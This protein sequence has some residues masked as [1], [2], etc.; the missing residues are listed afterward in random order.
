[1]DQIPWNGR[2]EEIPNARFVGKHDVTYVRWL[3]FELMSPDPLLVVA[4]A[5]DKQHKLHKLHKL[6]FKNCW[7]MIIWIR[8]HFPAP[9][10]S[11]SSKNSS[12]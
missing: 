11:H 10:T 6:E 3:Y 9:N 2:F 5:L 8:Q 1:M 7:R 4:D 12:S